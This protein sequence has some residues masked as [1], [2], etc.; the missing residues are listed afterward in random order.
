MDVEIE[1]LRLAW[2]WMVAHQNI[3]NIQKSLGSLWHFYAFRG[4]PREDAGLF[5]EA[6]AALEKVDENQADLAN[7][8]QATLGH[9]LTHQG[10]FIA[11]LDRYE[12]ADELLQQSLALLRKST[13]DH[14]L[15]ETLAYLA[16]LKCRQGD[17]VQS[18]Q[19]ALESLE[20]NRALD[21]Q[22]GIMYCLNTL[23][24]I[25]LAQ[26]AYRQAYELSS[27]SLAI[28][29]ELMGDP[30]GMTE[31]LI[32]LSAAARNLGQHAKAKR[33]A[34]ESL[35]I[36]KTLHDRWGTAQ[37]LRQ[38]GLINLELGETRRA[39]ILI[40]ESVSQARE[41]GDRTLTATALIGLGRVTARSGAYSEAKKYHLE[42]LRTAMEMKTIV[43]ALQALV[44]IAMIVM[45]E[46]APEMA[47][48]LVIFSLN[49]PA[50]HAEV[51]NRAERLRAELVTQLTPRQIEAIQAQA[52]TR[53]LEILAGQIL[54]SVRVPDV[55]SAFNS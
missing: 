44:E 35:Q 41:I 32:A 48:E 55:M 21:T 6:A 3:T 25:H 34:R 52:Q 31:C 16:N 8:R 19:F 54:D 36:S 46:G 5:G 14:A 51:H 33:W 12:E 1:N 13:D 38:L 2:S 39:E 7:K 20:L 23:S 42:A 26:G 50:I 22:L 9:L 27:E 40:R 24:D 30:H 4:R 28:C 11:Y 17:F 15:A 43:I 47:L 45:R 29:R 18:R 10:Y 53:T 37:I 49:H